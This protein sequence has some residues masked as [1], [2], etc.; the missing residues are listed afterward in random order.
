MKPNLNSPKKVVLTV[1][2]TGGLHGKEAN[3]A[4]PEQPDEIVRAFEQSY[5][6]GASV[7]HIHVRAKDGKTSA[8]PAIYSE[9]L[10]GINERCPGMITQ[11]GN[12]IGI[13]RDGAGRPMTFTQAQRMALCDLQPRPDMLTVNA[14]TFHF[15]HKGTEWLFDNSK[16]WNTGFIRACRERRIVNELEVYDLSHIENML[17]LRDKGI[18]AEPLHFSFVMGIKGGIPATPQNLLV[19]LD[20]IPEGSSWQLITIGR[21]QVPLTTMAAA[22]GGNLRV[23]FEDNVYYRRGELADS[24]TQLVERAVRIIHEI[25]RELAGVEEARQML[26]IELDSRVTTAVGE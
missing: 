1:A 19:M 7:A 11:V 22:M 25:G 8:D 24:N 21:A 18:L 10:A 26:G 4:L 12:G 6:A 3:P 14:G 20:S 16:Q 17:E 13:T 2:T 5:R 23:G 15:D 9:V